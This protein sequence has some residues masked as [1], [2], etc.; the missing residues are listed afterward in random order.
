LEKTCAIPTPEPTATPAAIITLDG[1]C[2]LPVI[3]KKA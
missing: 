1:P 3:W 2:F